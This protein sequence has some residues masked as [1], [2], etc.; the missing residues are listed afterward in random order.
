M[1][2]GALGVKVQV[3]LSVAVDVKARLDAAVQA[4]YIQLNAALGA[5]HSAYTVVEAHAHEAGCKIF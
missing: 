4:S 1:L 5:A 2:S 3:D